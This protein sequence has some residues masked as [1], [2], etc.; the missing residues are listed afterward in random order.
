MTTSGT[1]A[2]SLATQT[3]N[4]VW[5][6]P[7]TGAAANPTF[8]ALVTADIPSGLAYLT[9]IN[10]DTT[11]AQALTV[12]TAG[13]DFAITNPGSGSHVFNLPTASASNRGALSS[14]DWTTFNNKGSGTVT[15]VSIASANGFA[16]SSSGGATPALTL[17]TSI[18]G[19]LKGNATAISAATAGTDYSAGTSALS[20]GILKSTTTTGALTIAVAGD[21]PTLN[22]NTSGNAA[23]VTTNAN[24]TGP[25][26]SVGNATSIAA[27][28]GTGTTFAM[29]ASP[30][31]TGVVGHA[32]G[33]VGAPSI[34]FTGSATTGLYARAADTVTISIAGTKCAEFG[35]NGIGIGSNGTVAAG[36][37][38]IS[39][40][41]NYSFLDAGVALFSYN[42][43]NA[44][45]TWGYNQTGNLYNFL[46]AAG[47]ADT[48]PALQAFGST[49]HAPPAVVIR[50]A[51]T[52]VGNYEGITT[53]GNSKNPNGGIYVFNDVHT[54]ASEDS[55][56]EFWNAKAGT[57]AKKATITKAGQLTLETAG[58]GLSIKTGSNCKMGTST[59]VGGTVTVSTT[60]VTAS[61]LIFLS[62]QNGAG[63]TGS[64]SLGTVTAGT[65]FVINSTSAADT[66]LIAWLI[67]EPS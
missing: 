5:A 56:I 44:F 39:T 47:S 10:S 40:G 36:F 18:T 26:T 37:G 1:L 58:A 15:A 67:M 48:N 20:T 11:A 28:T 8:R 63:V 64:L 24:L 53:C 13:T 60:A 35:V 34:Y 17:S 14:A 54:A 57:F 32:V 19:V 46:V 31:F 65:S 7:T 27:Q 3:A 23:T 52:T 29:S 30:S 2:L 33:A 38:I 49:A 42:A 66:A 62:N 25:I 41:G 6:G 61:S 45:S 21:F 59:L 50:N 4:M 55:R 12:G 22:Q 9:S 16:G 51:N 43:A